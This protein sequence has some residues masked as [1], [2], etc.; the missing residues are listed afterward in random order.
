MYACEN[1]QLKKTHLKLFAELMANGRI[2]IRSTNPDLP[3]WEK[4]RSNGLCLILESGRTG[5]LVI[6]PTMKGENRFYSMLEY[7]G[8]K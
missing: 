6:H 4:L 8:K 5:T 7:L 1:L 3:N 2:S